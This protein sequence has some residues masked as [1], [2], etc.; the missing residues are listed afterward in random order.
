ML[1][2]AP[3]S[4]DGASAQISL[5][6]AA[7]AAV[8]LRSGLRAGVMSAVAVVAKTT[9]RSTLIAAISAHSAALKIPLATTTRGFD[10]RCGQ[11]PV[12]V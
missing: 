4:P 12:G 2:R 7:H 5:T 8:L 10:L 11:M 1:L 9:A 6:V 3:K